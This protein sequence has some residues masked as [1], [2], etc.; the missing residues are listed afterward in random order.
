MQHTLRTLPNGMRVVTIPLHDTQAISVLVFTKV[1]SRYE[2]TAVNGVSHFIEHLMF[3]GTKKRPTTLDISKELDGVGAQYNAYTSKDATCYY[4]KVSADHTELAFDVLSDL[5]KNATFDPKEIERERGVIVE[6]I[7]MYDDNPLLTIE[8]IFEQVLFGTHHPLGRSILGPKKVIQTISRT[9]ILKYKQ[10]YYQAGNMLVVISGK[11]PSKLD[12]LVSRYFGAFAKGKK[13]PAF[14]PYTKKENS[15]VLIQTRESEQV[16]VALGVPALSYTDRR[17]PILSVLSNILGGTM[18]SRL[19]VQVREKRGLAYTVRSSVGAYEDIGAFE[20]QAGLD[21]SKLEKALPVIIAEMRK[22][23]TTR[24]SRAE[25]ERA[26]ENL[27]GGMILG[28]EDSEAVAAFYGRQALF[29]KRIEPPQAALDR[30]QKVTAADVQ[31]LAQQLF[32]ASA[33]RLAIIGPFQSDPKW[34]EMLKGL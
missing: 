19:F 21:K 25:L 31:R 15:P 3:K 30:L 4:L 2:P 26:K 20:I 6:E 18:S 24:V 32:R 10:K 12:Q 5:V 9:D 27:R 1:G 13:T 14:T 16:Q 22:M 17:L 23:K 33:L 11:I 28:L 7:N 34:A 29:K 8:E